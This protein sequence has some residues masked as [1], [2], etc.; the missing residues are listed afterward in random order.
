[1]N[2]FTPA[3]PETGKRMMNEQMID[4]MELLTDNAKL[5]NKTNCYL[6]LLEHLGKD[7]KIDFVADLN[8]YERIGLLACYRI[9]IDKLN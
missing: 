7:E 6:H 4:A 3:E 8:S 2:F 9:C 5:A 1:M